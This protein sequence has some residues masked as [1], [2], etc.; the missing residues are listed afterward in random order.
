LAAGPAAT[1]RDGVTLAS[2]VASVCWD[3]VPPTI[4]DAAENTVEWT[5]AAVDDR[6]RAIVTVALVPD[7][8]AAGFPVRLHSGGI[9]GAG[10]LDAAGRA[11]FDLVDDAGAAVTETSAWNHGW[12][13]TTVAVGADSSESAATRDRVRAFARARLARPGSD[14][15]LAETL[16]AEADY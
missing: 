15:F 3:A 2:G 8:S 16:A 6:V 5:V 1:G 11:E 14:A 12:G 4:F 9:G 7:A 13:T 10:V